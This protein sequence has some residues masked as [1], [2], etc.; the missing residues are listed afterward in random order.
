MIS[1][2]CALSY[3]A[4]LKGG[5][6]HALPIVHTTPLVTH[7]HKGKIIALAGLTLFFVYAIFALPHPFTQNHTAKRNNVENADSGINLIKK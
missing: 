1:D 4:F 7:T 6:I 2:I 3:L 5:L